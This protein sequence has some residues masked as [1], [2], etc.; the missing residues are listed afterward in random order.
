MC[1]V[2]FYCATWEHYFTNTLILPAVNGPT[3]GL[4]LIY[5]AHIFTSIVGS[6]WWAQDFG[7]SILLL[8][9]VPIINANGTDKFTT[10]MSHVHVASWGRKIL[11][12]GPPGGIC[13]TSSGLGPCPP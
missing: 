1:A 13:V 2:P 8:S 6:E 3:E 4:M 7:T 5:V 12:A 9:W 11:E 10:T